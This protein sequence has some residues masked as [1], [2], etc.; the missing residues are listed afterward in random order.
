MNDYASAH[1]RLGTE[2]KRDEHEFDLHWHAL[3][4]RTA[5]TEQAQAM[6]EELEAC[7]ER[8]VQRESDGLYE[9]LIEQGYA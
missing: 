5:S 1:V 8:L 9:S 6:W 4:Y 2:L 7:V 3:N